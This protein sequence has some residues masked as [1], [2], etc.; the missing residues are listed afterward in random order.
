M[1]YYPPNFDRNRAIELGTLIDAA[2]TQYNNRTNAG[3]QWQPPGYQIVSVITAK[4]GLETVPFGYVAV[5]NQDVYVVIRG[6]QEALEWLDDATIAPTPFHPGWGNTTKGFA[7]IYDQLSPQILQEI[8]KLKNQGAIGQL[9]VT[10]HS[11]GAA[12]AHL[13]TA[14]LFI[15]L[16]FKPISYTFSGPRT[17]DPAF[18]T[19]FDANGLQTWRIFNTEDIV[20]TLPLAAPDLTPT[21]QGLGDTMIE[22]EL[23]LLIA[24]HAVNQFQHLQTPIVISFHKGTIADNHNL[25]N[26]YRSL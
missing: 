13:A 24:T 11:L 9:F 2:Y 16:G 3:F 17:G 1:P 12:L 10:G 18:A 25:T 5:K 23:K 8:D 21:M 26:L 20:P 14:D 7:A 15:S 4:E 22:L 6:T 19:A